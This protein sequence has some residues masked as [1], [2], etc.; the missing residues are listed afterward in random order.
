V[1][2]PFAALERIGASMCE[3]QLDF[4]RTMREAC[5]ETMFHAIYGSPLMKT[6]GR[7]EMA[8]QRHRQG[9]NLRALPDVREALAAMTEG[10]AAAGA[11]R[12]LALMS[13]A[14]GYLRRSRL[15]RMLELIT[16]TGT[17]GRFDQAALSKLLR[18]QQIIVDLEPEQALATLPLLLE[19]A[20]ERRIAL[21]AVAEVSGAVQTMHPAALVL[22]QRFQQMLDAD[23]AMTAPGRIAAATLVAPEVEDALLA[24]PAEDAPTS[25]YNPISGLRTIAPRAPAIEA[26]A[27][28]EAADDLESL[29]GVGPRMAEK[30]RQLGIERYAQLAALEPEEEAW[31]DLKLNARGRVMREGWIGQARARLNGKVTG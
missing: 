26:A 12:M 25:S 18:Q 21:A 4:Y 24:G 28:G 13:K 30:L 16:H 10:G 7:H 19:S 29:M 11:V 27:E 5:M 23:G 17:L 6:I 8:G 2:N 15:E 22:M 14:R 31:L 20:D 9:K 3:R 1:D